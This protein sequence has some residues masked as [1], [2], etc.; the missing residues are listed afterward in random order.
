VQGE[1]GGC[2]SGL[3]FVDRKKMLALAALR[4]GRRINYFFVYILVGDL[5]AGRV[6]DKNTFCL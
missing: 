3:T 6:G 2:I 5:L 1:E 4:V